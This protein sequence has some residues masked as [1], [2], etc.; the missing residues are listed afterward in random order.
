MRILTFL[1]LLCAIQITSAQSTHNKFIDEYIEKDYDR[2]EA[3]YTHLHQNPELSFLEE[4][5][6]ARLAKELREIG[7]EVTEKIGGHGIVGILKNGEGPTVLIR[8]DMDAL[9]ILEET[10]MDYASKVKMTD[11]TGDEVSVMHACGHDIHMTVWTGAARALA[12]MKDH[13]KGTILFL[14]QPAEERGSGARNMLK[15]GLFDKFPVPDYGIALHVHAAMPA[16]SIGYCPEFSMANVD[17]M[18]IK[19][20]GEG[21]HGAYPHSTIDPVTLAAKIIVDIQTIVSREI[22]PLEPAVVTVGS[23][24]GGTKGNVIPNEVELKLTLRSYTDEVRLA[25]IDKIKLKCKAAAMAAGLSEDK[26]PEVTLRD[27]FTPA[28]YNDPKLTSRMA[29]VFVENFGKEKIHRQAP[30]MGGED[31]GMYGRTDAKIPIF[32]YRLGTVN[33]ERFEAYQADNKQLP[34]LHSSKFA[35]DREPSIKTGVR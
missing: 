33:P 20:F 17:M 11:I 12:K 32:M 22:S 26:Y 24:H 1:F 4:N 3:L 2:L 21:G 29:A 35:P 25:L 9:P 5:T 28:L 13:W 27:E 14:G 34:S 7:F 30:V 16:G 18:G 8:A 6:A 10:G 19:V 15:D 23:I 31:F